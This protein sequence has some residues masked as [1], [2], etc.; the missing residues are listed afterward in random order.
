[1]LIINAYIMVIKPAFWFYFEIHVPV[2]QNRYSGLQDHQILLREL[3]I[4]VI[5]YNHHFLAGGNLVITDILLHSKNI[6]SFLIDNGSRTGFLNLISY[7]ASSKNWKINLRGN[8]YLPHI[9]LMKMKKGE[10]KVKSK[11][12]KYIYIF[13]L[14]YE[15]A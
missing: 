12:G 6:L 11:R 5:G 9:S 1:M 3:L 8:L 7:F 13:T 2:P 4:S 10:R 14:S 15:Q